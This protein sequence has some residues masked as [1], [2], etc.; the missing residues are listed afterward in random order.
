MY[1]ITKIKGVENPIA[2]TAK[3]VDDYRESLLTSMLSPSLESNHLSPSVDYWILGEIIEGPE[4]GKPLVVDRWM[5][6]GILNRGVFYTS[7]ITKITEDGFETMNSVYK[8]EKADDE[9]LLNI[10]NE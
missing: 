6:N 9:D 5:R 7:K 4:V 2:Q 10:N 3:S 8:M 1:K